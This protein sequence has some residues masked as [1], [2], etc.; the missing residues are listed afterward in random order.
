MRF[1]DIDQDARVCIVPA[2]LYIK[3]YIH[4]YLHIYIYTQ[5]IVSEPMGSGRCEKPFLSLRRERSR[6]PNRLSIRVLNGLAYY[7]SAEA[8]TFESKCW[9]YL[10][11]FPGSLGVLIM[12]V[13][14]SS[15]VADKPAHVCT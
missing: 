9:E 3:T 12:G 13:M 4:T 14:S 2:C 1:N 10:K 8:A 7:S 11:I 15:V 6:T 5:S